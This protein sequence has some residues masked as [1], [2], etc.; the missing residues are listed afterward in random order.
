[1]DRLDGLLM[2]ISRSSEHDAQRFRPIAAQWRL[3]IQNYIRDLTETAE[4][5]Q[6]IDSPYITGIPLTDQQAIFVGRT[7]ISAKIEQLIADRR[8]PPLL[9]YGQRRMGK[10]SLLLNL[11][12]LLPTTIVPLYIDLQGA[13]SQASNDSG[14]LYNLARNMI[15]AAKSHDG[16]LLPPLSRDDLAQDPFPQFDEWLDS[17][18]RVIGNNTLLLLLD[19]FEALDHA[20]NSGRFDPTLVLGMLRHLIQHR[21]RF[22][23]LLAGSHTLDEL[24]RWSSYFINVQVVKIDYLHEFEARQLIEHPVADFSLRYKPAASQRVWDLTRGHPFLIQLLCEEIVALKNQQ[25]P[26]QRRLANLVDVEAAIPQALDHGRLF[27]DDIQHNQLVQRDVDFLCYLAAQGGG[28]VISQEAVDTWMRQSKDASKTLATLLQRD[29]IEPSNGGY[30]FQVELIRR[31]FAQQ[32]Q[33]P[34]VGPLKTPNSTQ[35]QQ[36]VTLV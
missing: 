9:L 25:D 30:R 12:R 17:V 14:F 5:R 4:A 15:K 27:F 21:Q 1:E 8:R 23:V 7:D 34:Q 33:Q 13:P 36:D 35:L 31:W 16:L 2:E 3:I 24:H 20:L 19:E 18:E 22:K 10:T 29:L 26:S 32:S 6:E 11:R 28:A